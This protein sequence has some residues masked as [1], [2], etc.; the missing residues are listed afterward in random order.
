MLL[1]LLKHVSLFVLL[2]CSCYYWCVIKPAVIFVIAVVVLAVITIMVIIVIDC[3]CCCSCC[4]CYCCCC[5]NLDSLQP[6][7][8]WKMLNNFCHQPIS[9]NKLVFR[10]NR[11]SLS[12]GPQLSSV[13]FTWAFFTQL[14][15]RHPQVVISLLVTPRSED[16]ES[17]FYSI[18]WK[19][20]FFFFKTSKFRKIET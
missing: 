16:G 18:S 1:V 19:R 5:I 3:G 9:T 8:R 10:R 6:T 13:A 17:Y 12:R 14:L 4:C 11:L 2:S 20:L 7:S 15:V